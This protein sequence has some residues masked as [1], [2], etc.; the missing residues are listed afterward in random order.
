MFV[1]LLRERSRAL[2]TGG[3]GVGHLNNHDTAKGTVGIVV[4]HLDKAK[5][6]NAIDGTSALGI[7]GNLNSIGLD[8]WILAHFDLCT[9]SCKWLLKKCVA[10]T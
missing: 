6:G 5:A 3:G 10:L 1:G 8:G 7:S 4:G 9:A 2:D